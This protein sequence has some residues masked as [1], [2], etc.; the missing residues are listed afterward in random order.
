MSDFKASIYHTVLPLRK[1]YAQGGIKT[2]I[3]EKSEIWLQGCIHPEDA[4]YEQS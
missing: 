3:A 1:I 2:K 4:V